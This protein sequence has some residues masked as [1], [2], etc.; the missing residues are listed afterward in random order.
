MKLK[1]T[2]GLSISSLLRIAVAAP[3]IQLDRRFD[4]SYCDRV[5]V[6]GREITRIRV[7][8]KDINGMLAM[9][10]A[11]YHNGVYM[12]DPADEP[13]YIVR[14][15]LNNSFNT[16]PDPADSPHV[17][18]TGKCRQLA[19][20]QMQRHQKYIPFGFP[21]VNHFLSGGLSR[22]EFMEIRCAET[23]IERSRL[24]GFVLSGLPGDRGM[25]VPIKDPQLELH[26]RA[27]LA[28]R[29]LA[30]RYE[31]TANGMIPDTFHKHYYA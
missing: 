14:K 28:V 9:K 2:L 19:F 4:G 17:N 7:T 21:P 10:H 8:P 23:P 27:H 1:N 12:G 30:K 29:R 5:E 11:V 25:A 20:D 16:V 31:Y 24:R 13:N 15:L 6:G 22:S 18:L 3:V 26:A